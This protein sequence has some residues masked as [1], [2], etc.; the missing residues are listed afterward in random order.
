MSGLLE[1]K[2]AFITGGAQGIGLA[3]AEAYLKHG[4]KVIAADIDKRAVA[5]AQS[6]LASLAGDRARVVEL[7]VTNEDATEAL[8]DC[9][10]KDGGVD[11]VVPNAGILVL[12]RAVDIDLPTWRR[13]LDI[14]LTGAFVTA[15]SFARRMVP[16]GRGGR[17]ILTSSLFGLRGGV[18]NAA[19][20]ASKFGMIG[21]MQCLAAELAADGILVNCVC[22]GQMD[23]AMLH[24]LFDARAVLQGKP[25]EELKAA[26]KAKIPL[27]QLGK[28]DD[29]AGAY[30][31][32]ASDLARYVVGQSL[33]IDGG[34]QVG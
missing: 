33:V 3:V 24:S 2:T 23:T 13:V 1:G 5:G 19:Y 34:W 32:L 8:A 29:L 12:K 25:A 26:F 10:F 31:Y 4:A 9:L 30:V 11:I 17:I 7:D 14:N 21:L 22:P 15:T 28:L 27:G 20:S 18:E 16:Q 6:R